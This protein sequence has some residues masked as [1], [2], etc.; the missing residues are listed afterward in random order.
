MDATCDTNGEMRNSYYLSVGNLE[1]R[2]NFGGRGKVGTI[3]LKWRTWTGLNW[4]IVG[5]NSEFCEHDYERFI[6]TRT[7]NFFNCW[8]AI[9]FLNKI[10]HRGWSLR[11]ITPCF[12]SSR[13]IQFQLS[14]GYISQLSTL[15]LFPSRR[16]YCGSQSKPLGTNVLTNI[17]QY[18]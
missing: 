7:R 18:R 10:K 9:S 6:S 1:V 5:F 11:Y 12:L 8:T 13:L 4:L 16:M 2:T 3:A 17:L 15:L 14:S